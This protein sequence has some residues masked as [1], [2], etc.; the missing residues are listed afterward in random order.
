MGAHQAHKGRRPIQAEETSCRKVGL[1]KKHTEVAERILSWVDE[2]IW[3][4]AAKKVGKVGN[5]A[6][7]EFGVYPTD[8]WFSNYTQWGCEYSLESTGKSSGN[9]ES[10]AGLPALFQPHQFRFCLF[11]GEH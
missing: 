2:P 6:I 1:R 3:R 10:G 11:D 5:D 8:L 4:L 9:G 7:K